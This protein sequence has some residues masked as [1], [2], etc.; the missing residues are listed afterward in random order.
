MFVSILYPITTKFFENVTL[1][2]K[3]VTILLV[4]IKIIFNFVSFNEKD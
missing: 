2:D 1:F 4:N 3:K